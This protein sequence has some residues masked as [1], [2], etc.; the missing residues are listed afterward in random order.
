MLLSVAMLLC[1]VV[2]SAYDFVVDSIYYDIN[3][4]EVAVTFMK[5]RNGGYSG[6]VVIPDSVTYNE[7]T[8]SVT[9]IGKD[10]FYNC[11]GLT[12]VT[13]GNSVTSIGNSAFYRCSSLTSVTIPNSVTS[14]GNEAFYNC[15]SLTSVTIPNSV[16]SIGDGAFYN[17]S[18]LTSIT[19]PNSVTSIGGGAFYNCSSLTSVTIGNSVTSIGSNAFY[20]CTKLKK[21]INFSNLIFTEWSSSNGFVAYYADKVINL[22]NATLEGDFVFCEVDSVNTLYCYVGNDSVITLPENYKGQNYS[23]GNDAFSGCRGL[24]SITIPNSVT[25]IGN[26]AFSGCSGLTSITIPN[27]VTS[28]GTYA[29]YYCKNLTNIT[30]PNSV[31]SI[32]N[33]AFFG[34]SGLTSITIPGSVTSIGYEVFYGC[35]SLINIE[36]SEKVTTLPYNLLRETPWYNNQPDGVVYIGKVLYS[37]KGEM[38]DCTSIV[39]NE[40]TL[41]ITEGA[42]NG[43]S[44]L[45]SITIP[46]SVTSIGRG[47]FSGCNNLVNINLESGNSVYDSRDNCNAIIETATNTFIVGCKNSVIPNSVTNIAEMAFCDCSGLTSVTIPNSVT[48]IGDNAFRNCCGLT[49]VT[50]P[51]SVTCIGSSAFEGC[52]AL[53]SVTIPNSVTSIGDFVFYGCSGLASVTIPNSVTSIGDYAFCDCSG[54]ASVTIPTSVIS[55]GDFA[56]AGCS[57]LASIKVESGNPVYDSRENC[58]AIIETATNK[59]VQG[60]N[61]TIIPNSVTSI[62][63][64]AF[65]YFSGLTNITIPNS[66][67]SIDYCAFHGCSG[68]TSITIPGSVTVIGTDA[69]YGCSNLKSIFVLSETPLIFNSR[70]PFGN[71][72]ATLY[73]PQGSLDAYKT[74]EGWGYFTNIVEFDP[75]DIEDVTEEDAPAFEITAGG[76]QFTAAEGKTV[77]VYTANGALVEKIDSYAGEEIALDKGVYVIRVAEKSIKVKL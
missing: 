25:S 58:N 54:L 34:C 75:T 17:C 38:P 10:A 14:I 73:V 42:F 21:V 23:I 40:G 72:D 12:S 51:N 37:Y 59:L 27:G 11:S 8:Y 53:A 52:S 2:A 36:I 49:S 66:V 1:S 39:V 64:Y 47:L 24:T 5:R 20:N 69:F 16:T 57:G 33:F 74:S 43:C 28:I 30:I 35:S 29:F 48:S 18:S 4:D 77:A 67:T 76:I 50:I 68:L 41:G 6:N 62:G 9:S 46:N 70:L 19:I 15:S 71:Y 31:T 65:S 63:Y 56:F 22:P 7:K 60:C 26:D 13:I 3:G 45:T 55:I 61:N 32:G 44:G